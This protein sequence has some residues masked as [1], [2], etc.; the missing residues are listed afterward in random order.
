MI[1]LTNDIQAQPYQWKCVNCKGTMLK[2]TFGHIPCILVSQ[3]TFKLTF[4]HVHFCIKSLQI[5]IYSVIYFKNLSDAFLTTECFSFIVGVV[6]VQDATVLDLKHAIKRYVKLKQKRQ[7][8]DRNTQLVGLTKELTCWINS[9]ILMVSI[10][11]SLLMMI[12]VFMR[13]NFFPMINFWLAFLFILFLFLTS[14]VRSV[15]WK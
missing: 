11:R 12:I 6:V 4:V 3:W 15:N 2:T 13:S 9:I 1:F 10:L 8:G 5:I 7:N 14:L